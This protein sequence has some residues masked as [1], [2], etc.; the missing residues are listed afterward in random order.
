MFQDLIT[1]LLFSVDFI[2]SDLSYFIEIENDTNKIVIYERFAN[3]LKNNCSGVNGSVCVYNL[4]G[5]DLKQFSLAVYNKFAVKSFESIS[6]RDLKFNIINN[7][8]IDDIYE[9]FINQKDS[10]IKN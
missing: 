7:I 2:K 1:C 3:A 5:K 9:F 4:E 8:Q 10:I 6:E